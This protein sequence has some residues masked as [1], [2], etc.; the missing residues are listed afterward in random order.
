[1]KGLACFLCFLM[2][3]TQIDDCWVTALPLSSATQDDDDEYLPAPAG[4]HGVE[5]SAHV[6]PVFVRL[7]P[8]AADFSLPRLD[9]RHEWNLTSPFTPPPLYAFMSLQI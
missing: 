3:W 4:P 2:I 9:E 6:K 5:C 8:Q 7:K 1:M